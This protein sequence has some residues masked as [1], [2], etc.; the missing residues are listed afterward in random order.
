MGHVSLKHVGTVKINQ[1]STLSVLY[2]DNHT[3]AV[4]KE[5]GWVVQGAAEG[6]PSLLERVR[7]Y[8]K[9]KYEKPG[10]VYLGTLHR[11]DRWV[12]GVVLFAK[13]SKA[14]SRI[15]AQMR[16]QSIQKKYWAW[17]EKEMSAVGHL[18]DYLSIESDPRVDV[19]KN[20]LAGYKPSELRFRRLDVES[21]FGC[22]LEIELIT[23][24]K[25]QIRAQLS[26]QNAPIV[27]DSRYGSRYALASHEIALSS[28]EMVFAH[29][30]QGDAIKVQSRLMLNELVAHWAGAL[31]P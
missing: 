3:I 11:L 29:P 7:E 21:P 22:L 5:S 1:N 8:L 27:G 25:H 26:A 10:N 20:A 31:Q 17:V 2:E 6:T 9:L 23:G 4:W 14:A 13:T 16:E 30:T 15:S 24:R 19:S 28:V 12:S 18:K